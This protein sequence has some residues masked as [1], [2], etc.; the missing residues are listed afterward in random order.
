MP[1]VVISA[2]MMMAERCDLA[3]DDMETLSVEQIKT[4]LKLA[5][6]LMF[7]AAC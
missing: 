1:E 5:I 7:I 6:C 4:S 2:P 3:I